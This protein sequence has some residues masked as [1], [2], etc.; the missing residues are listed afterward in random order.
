MIGRLNRAQPSQEAKVPNAL[1]PG[2]SPFVV[3]QPLAGPD[4]AVQAMPSFTPTTRASPS[5]RICPNPNFINRCTNQLVRH[6]SRG[7]IGRSAEEEAECAGLPPFTTE[8][9]PT[10]LAIAAGAVATTISMVILARFLLIR[11]GFIARTQPVADMQLPELE[12]TFLPYRS[13]PSP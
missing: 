9:L 4:T 11:H 2:Y 1:F 5:S 10:Y 8:N 7:R 13:E 3:A 12:Q 6:L